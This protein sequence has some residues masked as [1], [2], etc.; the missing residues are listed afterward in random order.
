MFRKWWIYS[1]IN[2]GGLD[3]VE[4]DRAFLE[5][6]QFK[7]K[8]LVATDVFSRGMDIPQ[9]NLIIN[10]GLPSYSKETMEDSYIHSVGRSG[11][12]NR[13]GFVIDFVSG[14]E[15]LS[16]LNYIQTFNNTV[17]KKFTI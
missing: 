14:P 1:F 15:D 9:V 11:R 2:S 3:P 12:F 7:T 8:I 13:S 17:S 5:F 4:R 10:Y 16:A 6:S